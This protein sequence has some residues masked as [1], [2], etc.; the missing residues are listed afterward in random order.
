MQLYI[1]KLDRRF[2]AFPAFDYF[3]E[4]RQW[5]KTNNY[6]LLREWCWENYGPGCDVD[7]RTAYNVPEEAEKYKWTWQ[8]DELRLFFKDG[9]ELAHL[10]LTWIK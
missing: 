9:P 2:K 10:Q 7:M 3:V 8:D 6:L 1:G 5:P 4:I